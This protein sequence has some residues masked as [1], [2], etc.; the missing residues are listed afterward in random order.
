MNRHL[1]YLTQS[2]S[3]AADATPWEKQLIEEGFI[4]LR[5]ADSSQAIAYARTYPL[6]GVLLDAEL[7]GG[8][9]AELISRLAERSVAAAPP[10]IGVL[11][12]EA[13]N[14]DL[15][16]LAEAG[17][18]HF[19]TPDT[20][21]VFLAYLLKTCQALQD[22]KSFEQTGM[23]ARSL[24]TESRK[25][26]HDLSQPLAVLQGRLQLMAS[27]T[28]DSDPRKETFKTMMQM[29]G[30][31]TRYLRELQELQRKYS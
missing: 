24:A 28:D 13:S 2:S 22:L 25:L 11:P 12:D 19:V 7:I 20:P 6:A 1:V 5:A 31:T 3:A 30:E 23:D 17:F 9:A 18:H 21:P 16:A 15:A 10:V 8:G 29:L 26:L 14:G 4:F 27:K